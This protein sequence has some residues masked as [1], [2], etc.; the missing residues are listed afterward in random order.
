MLDRYFTDIETDHLEVP[1]AVH[2]EPL[3]D[4]LR[5]ADRTQR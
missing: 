5:L 3:M 1:V 4:H 2:G